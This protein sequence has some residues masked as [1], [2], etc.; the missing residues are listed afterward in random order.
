MQTHRTYDVRVLQRRTEFHQCH[1]ELNELSVVVRMGDEFGGTLNVGARA[2]AGFHRTSGFD[3]ERGCIG[4][5]GIKG[6]SKK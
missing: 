4:G 1:V 5:T 3:A 6:F 2:F